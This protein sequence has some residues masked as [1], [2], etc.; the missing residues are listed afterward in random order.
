MWRESDATG[1]VADILRSPRSWL[2]AQ[3]SAQRRMKLV[4][5]VVVETYTKGKDAE[6]KRETTSREE[7]NI[8][9]EERFTTLTLNRRC[10]GNCFRGNF[11]NL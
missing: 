3:S 8:R 7:E 5:H 4:S 9:E 2:V 1:N 11:P 10:N 6:T